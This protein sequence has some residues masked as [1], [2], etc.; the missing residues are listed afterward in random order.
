MVGVNTVRDM[1][2]ATVVVMAGVTA[3]IVPPTTVMVVTM[4]IVVTAD[5]DATTLIIPGTMGM[6]DTT[7]GPTS[8]TAIIRTA[9]ASVTRAKVSR[10]GWGISST[11]S[12][13]VV[14]RQ[15]LVSGC[16]RQGASPTVR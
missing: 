16:E 8:T 7:V 12:N 6:A 14:Y 5:M 9:M 10:S 1:V 13:D 4:V 15:S 11:A 2:A 3:D